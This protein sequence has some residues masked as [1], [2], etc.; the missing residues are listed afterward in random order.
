M[1]GSFVPLRFV[2][3]LDRVAVGILADVGRAMAEVAFVPTDLEARAF[4]RGDAAFECLRTA[5]AISDV[6]EPSLFGRG[7]LQRMT[8]VIVVRAQVNRITLAAAFGHAHHVD[9]EAQAFLGFRREQFE[10]A[11]VGHVH[12]RFRLHTFPRSFGLCTHTATQTLNSRGKLYIERGVERRQVCKHTVRR[13]GRP[14]T[15]AWRSCAVDSE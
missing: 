4:Q 11:Q 14:T 2:V 10:V 13:R 8:L 1:G 12:N 9:E 7:E 6:A 5:G 15:R 3:K